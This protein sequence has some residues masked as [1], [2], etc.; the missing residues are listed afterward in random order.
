MARQFR[1]CAI[2]TIQIAKAGIFTKQEAE[3]LSDV[4]LSAFIAQ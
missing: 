3:R 1:Y 4:E 2:A